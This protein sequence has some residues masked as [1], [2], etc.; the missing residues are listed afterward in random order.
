MQRTLILYDS[1]YGSTEEV[2]EKLALILGPA[3]TCRV[4]DFDIRLRDFEFF[5]IGFPVY[6]GVISPSVWNFVRENLSWLAERHIALFCTCLDKNDG[7]DNLSKLRDLL[8]PA[9]IASGPL[10]GRMAVERLDGK[11][12]LGMESFCKRRDFTFQDIDTLSMEGVIDFALEVKRQRDV[13]VPSMAKRDLR[14]LVESFLASHNT[15]TLA[16]AS[17]G[18]VRATPI[19]YTYQDGHIYLLSEGGEKFANLLESAVVSIA[20]YDP[21]ES[22]DS[23][24]GLQISGTASIVKPASP[25]FRSILRIKGIKPERLAALLI[26]LNL[27]KIRLEKAEFLYAKLKSR[28]HEITQIF[29]FGNER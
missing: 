4:G 6:K 18:R 5:V 16:T 26:N 10:G 20:V 17:R 27:I 1:R 13:L 15:C 29:F 12:L 9:V 7:E 2:A 3:K 24:A 8:G 21:Y 11:D 19:E 23:V 14:V 25:E 22:M 28:G